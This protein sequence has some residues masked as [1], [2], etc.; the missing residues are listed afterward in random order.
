[1]NQRFVS[2]LISISASSDYGRVSAAVVSTSL[3]FPTI[4]QPIKPSDRSLSPFGRLR[5]RESRESGVYPGAPSIRLWPPPRTFPLPFRAAEG[6]CGLKERR[7]GATKTK[8]KRDGATATAAILL[9][10][11]PFEN[12]DLAQKRP[13]EISQ[14]TKLDSGSSDREKREGAEAGSL[15]PDRKEAKEQKQPCCNVFNAQRHLRA[16]FS[17]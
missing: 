4:P 6:R 7:L 16:G 8:E 13:R 10:H 5:E 15:M 11:S 9:P 2:G 14:S 1:M 3:L 17:S 12:A